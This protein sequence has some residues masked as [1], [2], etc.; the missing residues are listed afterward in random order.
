[1]QWN[2]NWR[3]LVSREAPAHQKFEASGWHLCS[4]DI[5]QRDKEHS[6]PSPDGQL[7]SSSLCRQDGGTHS[8]MSLQACNLWHWCLQRSIHLSVEYL[9]AGKTQQQIRSPENCSHHQ[10]GCSTKKFP[11]ILRRY[12]ANA[13]QTC[14][15][16]GWT[17]SC[18]IISAGGRILLPKGQ[19][20]SA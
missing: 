10:S 12:W 17:T 6:S 19:V 15:Q 1:M 14:L 7:I 9:Q 20:H 8:L 5:Y 3:P 16:P 18:R 11:N 13:R 2:Q 4:P